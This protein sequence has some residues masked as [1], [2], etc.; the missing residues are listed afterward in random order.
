M[1][2]FLLGGMQTFTYDSYVAALHIK[3]KCSRLSAIPFDASA[4]VKKRK[5]NKLVSSAVFL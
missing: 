3:I 1:E 4:F 5:K 2:Q